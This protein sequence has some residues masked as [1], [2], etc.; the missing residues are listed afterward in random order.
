MN[1][2]APF[3]K[4]PVMTVLAMVAII[5]AG[6]ICYDLLPISGMPNVDFPTINV[7][8]NF[9]G[10]LPETMANSVALPLEKQFMAIPG[11]R[12]VSSNNI[13][14]NSSI[15]LQFDI[16]KD[17]LTASQDVQ[18]AVST[19]IPNLPPNLPYGP[20]YRKF[21][22]AQQPVIYI[23]LTSP[24]IPRDNLYTYANTLI[25]QRI[26]MID[27]VSQ[28][29]TFGS[30][31][32]IRI[33]ADPQKLVTHSV[34]LEE[35]ASAVKKQNVYLPTG[36]LD[37]DIEAP[38]IFVDGAVSEVRDYETMIIAYRNGTPLR[39]QDIGRVV[40]SF[41]N[42]KIL[43]Q[44]VDSQ[45]ASPTIVLA[46]QKEPGGNTVAIADDIYRLL[47]ELKYQLPPAIDTHVIFD[48]SIPV[49]AA[50]H[51]AFVTLFFALIMV[52][53][54]IYL[55]LGKVSETIIPSLVMPMTVI[56]TFIVM[57][58]LDFTLNNLTVLALTLA[59]GFIIDDAVVVLENIIRRVEIGESPLEA[60][61]KG[62]GEIGFTI[63]SMTL[64][65]LAVFIPM[66]FMGGMIGKIFREFAITLAVV[67]IISGFISLTL[68]PML[69][70]RFIST[71]KE[72]KNPSRMSILSNNAN[73]WMCE[74]Y[75]RM[76][77]AVFDHQ[78]SALLVALGSLAA[79]LYL[80]THIPTDFVPN[81]DVG[82][83]VIYTQEIEGGSSPRMLDYE[84]RIIELLRSYPHIE[85]F[86]ALSS[87]NEYRKG[88]NFVRLKPQNQRPPINVV[89]QD[90]YKLLGKVEGVQSF[91]KNIPLID[92]AIGQE[93]RAAYQFALQSI[94]SDDLYSSARKLLA[95][96]KSEP[97]FQGVNS[98][99]EIDTPQINVKVQRDQASQYGIRAYDVE[100]V[101]NL[102][103][104]GNLISRIQT[105]IDQYNVILELYPELQQST[106]TLN[107]IWLRSPKTS[108]LIPLSAT[109]QWTEALGATSVNHINQFPSVTMSFNLAP[110]IPL[111]TALEKLNQL[112]VEVV[113]PNVSAI[114]I[115][116]AQTFNESIKTSGYLLLLTIFCI[117]II[118]GIL[119]ESF[120]H[121]LI[122]LTTLPP[123]MFGGLIVLY[124]FDMPLS[125]YSFLGIILLIGIVKKNG[126]MIVDFALD[127]VRMRGMQARDAIM[128]ASLVRFR[129]ILMTTLA[130]VFGV[131]PIALGVGANS[132]ARRPL[133]LVIIGG[134]LISQLITLFITPILF[135]GLEN[136]RH[137]Y[138]ENKR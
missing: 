50:I 89:I 58:M 60:S 94:N 61:L 132:E 12:I 66:L 133:G 85:T 109:M 78:W 65:L 10:A 23:A 1:I 29:T 115:G 81:E 137:R 14:G 112:T 93:S 34:T 8:S 41:Q 123:A 101:F 99:L 55:F 72:D 108:T 117:Y 36:Q 129:P 107:S 2:S 28:V 63:V 116:A 46:I 7:R 114:P 25:G 119:Y 49:R 79:T 37:G 47:D 43:G 106:E 32:A 134:L 127:N 82:F 118:L 51:D 95:K 67:T 83:F 9:P 98:D 130:A 97:M 13:L 57:Y 87:I 100:N 84:N 90:L 73:Q 88:L 136:L 77:S 74:R 38:I 17:I 110:G 20:V 21:N 53:M 80:L 138:T 16:D 86:V 3:I 18:A 54:V 103:Y 105:P 52:V 56:G 22:P 128:D 42:N 70:S 26:S 40:K 39:V 48:Q 27:G 33:Q 120:L 64:S 19:A 135:L 59:V 75:R 121:P 44:Y 96:M 113:E 126:I 31:L 124:L 68:T 102:A 69:S 125:L 91:I 45:G 122:I 4:R 35:V 6:M 62:A 76:L 30:I 15:V 104:A 92:L 131:L 11:L 71:G 24:T 5:V 111:E